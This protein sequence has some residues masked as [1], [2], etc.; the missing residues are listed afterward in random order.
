MSNQGYTKKDIGRKAGIYGGNYVAGVIA[1]NVGLNLSGPISKISGKVLENVLEIKPGLAN[2]IG[3]IFWGGVDAL[4][5][6]FPKLQEKKFF[7]VLE[8]LG[9]LY[10]GASTLT[11]LVAVLKGDWGAL[12]QLP[13]DVAMGYEV[14]KNF[15]ED[16]K[17]W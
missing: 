5:G 14:G 6:A 10:Y 16:I 7:H 3:G 12:A 11:D 17:N 13:F 1:S 2:P 4:R 9:A 8:G 15:A